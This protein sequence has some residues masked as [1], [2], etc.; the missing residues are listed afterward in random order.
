MRFLSRSD[1]A[2][3]RHRRG[4]IGRECQDVSPLLIGHHASIPLARRLVGL[5][6][7]GQRAQPIVPFGFEHVRDQAILWIHPEEASM[8]HVG[9]IA[10]ALDLLPPGMVGFG[11]AGDQLLLDGQRDLEGQG[12]HRL[13]EHVADRVVE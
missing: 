3:S 11:G 1:V 10:G 2:G 7:G 13:D 12:R 8:R 4:K 9:V 6:R 5:L